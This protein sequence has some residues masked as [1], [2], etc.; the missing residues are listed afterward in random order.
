MIAYALIV[1]VLL[2]QI[3]AVLRFSDRVE[4]WLLLRIA[5]L[6]ADWLTHHCV[7]STQPGPA[8]G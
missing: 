7:G 1:T 8:G 6:R 2:L 4:T 5:E 3:D